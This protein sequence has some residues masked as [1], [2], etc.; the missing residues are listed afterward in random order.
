MQYLE[1]HSAGGMAAEHQR[2]LAYRQRYGVD[3]RISH[4][5]ISGCFR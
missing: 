5:P 1:I 2:V 3:R 4:A